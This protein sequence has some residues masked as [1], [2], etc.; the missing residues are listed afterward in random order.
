MIGKRVLQGYVWEFRGN[1][2]IDPRSWR[3]F[4]R[5]N[6]KLL[7]ILESQNYWNFLDIPIRGPKSG[8]IKMIPCDV[9]ACREDHKST[10]LGSQRVVSVDGL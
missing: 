10:V 4:W 3:P 8:F 6:R 7:P 2:A 9:T 5:R 1:G